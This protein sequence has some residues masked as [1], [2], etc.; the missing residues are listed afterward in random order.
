MA[1]GNSLHRR[2]EDAA[3][4]ALSVPADLFLDLPGEHGAVVAQ[5]VL[6]LA[7]QQLARL[8]GAQPAEALQ[9]ADLALLGLLHA[10]GLMLEIARAVFQRALLALELGQ[11]HVQR[12][13]LRQQA[14]LD[15]CDLVAAGTQLALS[16]A[17]RRDDRR[18]G[19]G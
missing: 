9:L 18:G 12:L 5:L 1:A 4:A 14:L 2:R 3:G 19:S 15:A 6:E 7:Q 11:T 13:L 17:G 16:S 10:L 8:G